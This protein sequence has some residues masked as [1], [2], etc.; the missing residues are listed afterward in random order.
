MN[1]AALLRI[2]RA[3]LPAAIV[4][5]IAVPGSTASAQPFNL[6]FGLRGTPSTTYAAAG[7]TGH[8]STFPGTNGVTV[9]Q[10]VEITGNVT[11]AR[12]IQISGTETLEFTDATLQGD[13]A[14]LMNDALI[15]HTTIE[16]CV[17]FRDMIPGRYAVLIYARMPNR[18]D[19]VAVTS[20]DEEPGTPDK[21]V[22]G[23]WPG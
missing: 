23:V 12:F 21:L 1:N 7:R 2:C 13:D 17:F 16:N 4:F 20:V 5:S 10:L 11:G 6:D 19:I 22:G 18:P 9:T 3:T 8:W 14:L 15:T